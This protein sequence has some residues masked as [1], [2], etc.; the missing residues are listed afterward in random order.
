MNN[1]LSLK[2][3]RRGVISAYVPIS[4]ILV[5]GS[6]I[7]MSRHSGH[8]WTDT[9]TLGILLFMWAD[10]E[11]FEKKP[12]LARVLWWPLVFMWTFIHGT[13]FLAAKFL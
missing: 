13:Y 11:F 8:S 7:E 9:M 3:T 1:F 2:V 6:L 4:F 5:I 12:V 10:R